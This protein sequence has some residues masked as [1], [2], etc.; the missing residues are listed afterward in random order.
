M[1]AGKQPSELILSRHANLADAVEGAVVP[2]PDVLVQGEPIR[3]VGDLGGRTPPE[4]RSGGMVEASM[5]QHIGD[6]LSMIMKH[7]Q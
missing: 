7:A 4:A 5:R 1:A 6:S 3:E 2:D